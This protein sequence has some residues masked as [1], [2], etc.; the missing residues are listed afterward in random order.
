MIWGIDPSVTASGFVSL[1]AG[2]ELER[3]GTFPVN[4]KLKG[5]HRLLGLHNDLYS[6]YHDTIQLGMAVDLAVL[7]D[8]PRNAMGAGLT[9]MAQGIVRAFLVDVQVP[10]VTVA[11]ATLKKAVTGSGRAD[12]KEM[13]LAAQKVLG[14]DADYLKNDNEVDAW[15][16]AEVGLFY[17]GRSNRLQFTESLMDKIKLGT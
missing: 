6:A 5:S 11:P 15:G 16:L 12:K 9:G 17:K 3:T 10:F 2:G 1:H 13:K 14:E 8:L 7:E 4:R